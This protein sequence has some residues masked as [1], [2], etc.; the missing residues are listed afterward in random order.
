MTT[1]TSETFQAPDG[2][3]RC[4][5]LLDGTLCLT[6]GGFLLQQDAVR[7]GKHIAGDAKSLQ[8]FLTR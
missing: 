5:I 8:D 3:Y 7:C 2:T 4:R 1:S 6:S